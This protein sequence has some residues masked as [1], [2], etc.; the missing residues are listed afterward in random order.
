MTSDAHIIPRA[1]IFGCEGLAL[2]AA[3]ISFFKR[4]QPLGFILF[5]RNCENPAQ[6]HRLIQQLRA[7]VHHQDVPIL[8]DQEGGRVARLRPPLWRDYPPAA[9][10]GKIAENNL[11]EAIWCATVN[12]LL[13]GHEL[14]ELG[15]T[16]NCAPVVDL[17]VAAAHPIISD[18]SFGE[19]PEIVAIL[20]KAMIDGLQA[21]GIIPVIKHL[22]GHGRAVADSHEDLPV[23][24]TPTDVL[25]ETDFDA[26]RQLMNA[27]PQPD[28][29]A[30]VWGMTAHILY[31][32]IDSG[33]VATQSPI[34]LNSIVR[35]HIGFYGFLI[36]DCLTMKAL[37]GT[38][39]D[40]ASKSLK[41]GCDA[42]LHCS[43]VVDEMLD[44]LPH[45]PALSPNAY[46]R[47]RKSLDFKGAN[48]FTTPLDILEK[49]LQ[50]TL[51]PYFS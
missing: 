2:T 18:R 44:L 22:P 40:R 1:I 28:Y 41:A 39:G 50:Q 45:V 29:G 10:F 9:I 47:L 4:A 35:N 30:S 33:A 48:A 31:A 15:I 19:D 21:A 38:L 51:R 23:V 34:V 49:Q 12:A 17:N 42:V 43:G 37:S 36:S 13:L 7:C 32:A 20:S 24:S 5:A 25:A 46:E 14:R 26:F 16:V 27:M 11:D 8:I 6:I 3:E